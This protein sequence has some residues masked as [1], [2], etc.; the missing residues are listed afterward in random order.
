LN[1]FLAYRILGWNEGSEKY[2]QLASQP[3]RRQR[4]V[5]QSLEFIRKYDFDGLDLNWQYPS[6]R[7][8]DDQDKETFVLLVK[9]LSQEYKKYGLHLSSA[10]GA[11]KNIRLMISRVWR[12]IWTPS[13]SCGTIIMVYFFSFI[14]LYILINLIFH[15]GAWNEK[16]GLNAPLYSNDD[17]NVG[18]TIKYYLKLGA[19]AH[20]LIMGVPFYGRTFITFNEGNVGDKTINSYGFKG[21]FTNADSFLGYNEVTLIHLVDTNLRESL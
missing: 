13:T 12:L 5:K 17:S 15:P 19:P 1:F 8:G 3:E 16:V 6:N 4:F 20:K 9:E 11:A 10:F 18:S 2:S 14:P 7:G 21:P